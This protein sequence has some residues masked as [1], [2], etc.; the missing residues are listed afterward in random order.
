MT[1]ITI[2]S[3]NAKVLEGNYIGKLCT[4]CAKIDTPTHER[5]TVIL[6]GVEYERTVYERIVWRNQGENTV[7]ARFVWINGVFYVIDDSMATDDDEAEDEKPPVKLIWGEQ[8][9]GEDG[10]HCSVDLVLANDEEWQLDSEDLANHPGDWQ[11][12][13]PYIDAE[14]ALLSRNGLTRDN[15]V[16]IITPW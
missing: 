6:D 11:T 7:I 10:D 3:S 12:E 5:V 2:D 13:D 14:D 15:V 1:T 4:S 9:V 8:W 16:E